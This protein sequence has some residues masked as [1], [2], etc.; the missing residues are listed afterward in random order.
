MSRW[1]KSNASRQQGTRPVGPSN[2]EKQELTQLLQDAD[3]YGTQEECIYTMV[4]LARRLPTANIV[5][6]V[7]MVR[8]EVGV[9][10]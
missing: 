1:I 2:Q 3:L 7:Q 10:P 4:K 8:D 9:R 6:L 5:E